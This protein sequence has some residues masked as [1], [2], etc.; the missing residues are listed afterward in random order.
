MLHPNLFFVVLCVSSISLSLSSLIKYQVLQK[1]KYNKLSSSSRLV[2][3]IEEKLST[4]SE[5]ATDGNLWVVLAAGSTSWYN[6][7]HQADICHA[8][9]IVK[10]HGVPDDK[11]IVFM[12]D[13]IAHNPLNPKQGVIINRPGGPNVYTGVPK[14]YTGKNLNASIFLD[15]LAGKDIQVGS[16]KTLKT[17]P[18]DRVFIYFAD[19]GGP[20]ASMFGK[21]LLHAT[22]LTDTIL[23][24]HKNERYKEMVIYWESCHSG[25]MFQNLLPNN[26]NVYALSAS[27]PDQESYACY[28]DKDLRNYVGDCFSV[29]WMEDADI[30]NLNGET[31]LTQ[32]LITKFRTNTSTVE[33]W[34]SSLQMDD[35]KMAEYLGSADNL[36]GQNY[37]NFFTTN[38]NAIHP[39][40]PVKQSD[41]A[42]R[43]HIM[44][45]N[46]DASNDNG[47]DA[48]PSKLNDFISKRLLLTETIKKITMTVLQM[49]LGLSE[50]NPNSLLDRL[51]KNSTAV[52]TTRAILE[53]CFYP[54]VN[55]FNDNCFQLTCNDYAIYQVKQFLPLCKM[56]KASLIAVVESLRKSVDVHCKFEKP[57]C[58]IY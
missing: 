13:D 40:H 20:G 57:I 36:G 44:N 54:I 45:L 58:G 31:L 28:N 27:S 30:E 42:L 48:S 39:T 22:N 33:Q 26:I 52:S 34:G 3:E 25:S 7:R 1:I 15:V 19:H 46:N 43:V 35:E 4:M 53:Q 2:V 5:S 29:H 18:N 24:M 16:R 50:K 10:K 51:N 12:K 14:D 23:G 8:Y 38:T 11:I 32:Y 55:I 37:F 49:T 21:G 9:Q 41:V 6:Y 56:G 47:I 17:G